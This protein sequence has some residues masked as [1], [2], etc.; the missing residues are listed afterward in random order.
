MYVNSNES[1][2]LLPPHEHTFNTLKTG[3]KTQ[4]IKNNA[5]IN[6]SNYR[7]QKPKGCSRFDQEEGQMISESYKGYP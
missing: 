6:E 5:K 4:I 3:Q 2:V 7:I 1:L